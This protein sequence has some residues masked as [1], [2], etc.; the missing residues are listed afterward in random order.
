MDEFIP[1]Y[2]SHAIS[3]CLTALLAFCKIVGINRPYTQCL[4]LHPSPS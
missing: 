3:G 2:R 4:L 1:D